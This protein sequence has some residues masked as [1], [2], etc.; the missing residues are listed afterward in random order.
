MFGL[1]GATVNAAAVLAGGLIGLMIG[2][3][4]DKKI[5][6]AVMTGLALVVIYIGISGAFKGNNTLVAIISIA[7]GAVIG[8]LLDLDGAII[9]LGK[10]LE[11]TVSKNGNGNIARGFVSASLLFCVGAM[12]ITGPLDS[13]LTGN[14]TIQYTKALLDGI[15]AIVFASSLGVGVL[16]SAAFIFVYQGSI[17]LLAVY[18]KPFLNETVIN[19][20]T[21]VGSLLIMALGLNM[22][23][24]TKIK[25]MNYIPAVFLPI[26]LCMIPAFG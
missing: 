1:L 12:S 10:K 3:A 7:A 8:T 2:K 6:D 22:L 24:I 18:I 16:F 5:S 11:D 4:L 9:K 13:G 23:G 21:C 17:T 26:L 14:H 20:M 25:V 19:E 15:G